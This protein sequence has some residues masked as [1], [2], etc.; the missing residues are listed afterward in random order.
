YAQ[1]QRDVQSDPKSFTNY[2]CPSC[3]ALL[4]KHSYHKEGV[5]KV[6]LRCSVVENRKEKC[7]DVAFF[8]TREGDFWSPKHGVL[9]TLE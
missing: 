6:M 1:R 9:K 3:G 7:K 4:I 2:L 8:K 5:S